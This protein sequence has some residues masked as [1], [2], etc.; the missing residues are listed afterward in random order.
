MALLESTPNMHSPGVHF[1]AAGVL[2]NGIYKTSGRR[3]LGALLPNTITHTCTTVLQDLRILGPLYG[4]ETL[5]ASI[6]IGYCNFRSALCYF[7]G[8]NG[9]AVC[10]VS[11][12]DAGKSPRG[13]RVVSHCE[14]WRALFSFLSIFS[15]SAWA[16]HT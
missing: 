1:P 3:F 15:G 8:E 5:T 12:G 7:K 16:A 2:T 9:Q 11:L 6:L 10:S 13:C 14:R 4:G